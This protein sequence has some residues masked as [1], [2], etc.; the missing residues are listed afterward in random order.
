MSFSKKRKYLYINTLT[1]TDK[2]TFDAIMEQ[3]AKLFET[4]EKI[5]KLLK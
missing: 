1:M 5:Q 3:I 2:E 4:Q